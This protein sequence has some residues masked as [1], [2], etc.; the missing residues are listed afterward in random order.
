MSVHSLFVHSILGTKPYPQPPKKP[1]IA[2]IATLLQRKTVV[3]K[4][5]QAG[6]LDELAQMLR[7][8]EHPLKK[9][10]CASFVFSHG[11]PGAIMLIG[12]APGAQEDLEGKPFVGKSGQLLTRMFGTIG[13]TREDLYIT[14]IIPWRPPGNRTPTSQ[15]IMAFCPFIKEHVRLANPRVVILVGNTPLQAFFGTSRGGITRARGQ[16]MSL[17]IEEKSIPCMAIFHPAFLLRNPSRKKDS[18]FDLLAIQKKL[19]NL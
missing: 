2:P 15:E 8:F 19:K 18:W 16:W 10:G 12:E 6:S 9:S 17:D 11:S 7:D 13:Y 1:S 14:N 4:K 5:K 3:E